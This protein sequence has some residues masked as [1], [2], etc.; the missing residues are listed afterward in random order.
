M[1]P[2]GCK[3]VL[4]VHHSH[5]FDGSST[6]MV[7]LIRH[8]DPARFSPTVLIV[9]PRAEPL[10]SSIRDMGTPAH[11]LPTHLVHDLPW[12]SRDNLE[13]GAWRGFASDLELARFL[14][15]SP[16]DIVHINEHIPVSAGVTAH[17]LGFPVVWHC[18]HVFIYKRPFLDPSRRVIRTM[19][20]VAST[21]VCIDQ[22]EA[23]AFPASR[24]QIIHNPLDFA[25]IEA[26]RGGGSA[27][28]KALGVSSTEYL[29]TAPIP[30][31]EHKGAWDFIRACGVA[32]GL[33]PEIPMRFLLVGHL[34]RTGRRHLLRKWTGFVGPKPGLDRAHD[35]ARRAGIEGR[36]QFTGFR[37]DI[38][39]IMDGSDLIVF[40]SHTRA[41]GQPCFEAGG[42]SKA[43]RGDDASQER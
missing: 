18:R 41:C 15:T 39:E 25:R 40:P 42:L 9:H 30:M 6:S 5:G 24:V 32:A 20:E 17:K 2:T 12:Y 27:A 33:A 10:L 16:P 31:A 19:L 23:A 43:H 28:R 11:H 13:A 3:K 36:I 22:P 1:T 14:Q 34:P 38:Y 37:K 29:V 35:L 8:L 7:T 4:F 21:I 26:A